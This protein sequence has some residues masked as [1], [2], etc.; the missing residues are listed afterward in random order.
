M[1]H[2]MVVDSRL[3]F[4]DTW[5]QSPDTYEKGPYQYNKLMYVWPRVY[6]RVHQRTLEM[7]HFITVFRVL[8]QGTP[9]CIVLTATLHSHQQA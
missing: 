3:V 5:S 8:K 6:Q 9:V 7:I 1:S 2:L 4:I